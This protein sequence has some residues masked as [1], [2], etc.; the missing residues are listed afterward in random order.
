MSSTGVNCIWEGNHLP[1]W[2]RSPT[3]GNGRFRP[4]A[5]SSSTTEMRRERSFRPIWIGMTGTG[6]K[7]T[8]PYGR[9]GE[10]SQIMKRVIALLSLSLLA[11]GCGHKQNYA[12]GCGPLPR[13]WITPRQ[14]RGVLSIF[15]VLSVAS[16][17]SLRW[18]GVKVSKPAVVGYLKIIPQMNPIP[19]TQIK[20]DPEL[21]CETVKSIRQL[22]V[23]TLDCS[24][25]RCAEG[26]GKWWLIGDVVSDGQPN[27]PYDP[28]ARSSTTE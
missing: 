2:K 4:L 13:G 19:I 18:N 8:L 26:N 14:G 7:R 17:G 15:N 28:D 27:Q 16:N 21:D 1:Y 11:S 6:G 20:F 9:R 12:R 24:Y 10:Y 5:S 3:W 25:G 23:E 22:M